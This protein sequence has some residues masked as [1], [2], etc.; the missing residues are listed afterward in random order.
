M[1][2]V[3]VKAFEREVN[4][5]FLQQIWN[6]KYYGNDRSDLF[7]EIIGHSEIKSLF[8]KAINSEKPV[9]LLLVGCPGSAKTMFFLE[10]NRLFEESML[11]I[12]SNTQRPV[13][14]SLPFFGDREVYGGDS[15]HTL[16]RE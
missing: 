5:K 12:G 3:N 16:R 10:I 13:S 7:K 2:K 1:R 11:V 4:E 6:K 9:H 15:A 14:S 8:I